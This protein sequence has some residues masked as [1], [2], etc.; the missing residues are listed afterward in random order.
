MHQGKEEKGVS[1][2]MGN[3][4]R[5]LICTIMTVCVHCLP[6]SSQEDSCTQAVTLKDFT[7]TGNRQAFSM[8]NDK[9]DSYLW[10]M[11]MM[12]ELPKILG[13]ADPIHYSQMLPGVQTNNEYRS[14][15]NIQGC[16][17]SHNDINIG[18]IPIY[19][20]NHLLG[21]FSTF[22][23][24]HYPTMY[25]NKSITS[26]QGA[27]RLGGEL[28][29]SIPQDIPDSISGEMAVGVISSQGTLRAPLGQRTAV[30]LSLR[31]S[32]MNMLYGRWL[33]A[34]EMQMKYSFLDSNMTLL[35]RIDSINTL[36]ADFYGG[37][38]D[39]SFYED[40]Y[41]ADMKARWGN[42]MGSLRWLHNRDSTITEQALYITT[43]HNMF[44]IGMPDMAFT[45]PSSITDIGYKVRISSNRITG[46]L[47][48]VLHAITPQNVEN[49]G[50]AYNIVETIDGTTHTLETSVYADYRMPLTRRTQMTAGLR[51]TI[52][53]G[54]DVGALFSIDPSLSV[55]YSVGDINVSAAYSLCH[56]YIFQTGFSDMG[57]P[58][59]FWMSCGNG[60]RPQYA[61]TL[62]AGVSAYL[63]GRR[64]IV[65]ADVFYKKLYN[66]IE[67]NGTVLDFINT[68]YD[69]YNILVNGNGENH[70]FSIM[71]NKCSGI[72][73]GWISYAYTSAKRRFPS[74]GQKRYPSSHE[75]PHEIN[76]VLT[77]SVG[78]HWDFGTTFTYAS[79]T[80]FTAPDHLSLINGNIITQFSEYN[81]ARLKPYLRLD[82]SVNYKWKGR[83]HTRENSL[84]LS[85]YNATGRRNELF[86]YV[87]MHEDGRFAYRPVSFF[88]DIL[89]S[90]SYYCKF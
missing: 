69:I 74:I 36:I 71:V 54:E 55:K 79:G 7:V 30:T 12:N 43:Y 84:N 14:G 31:G 24:A 88:L 49:N 37:F 32:Y 16:E 77:C 22:N 76:S 60:R 86:Y 57:L 42:Y 52:Y 38:D 80:P 70:G 9:R 63:L 81:A 15:V 64:Y 2:Y 48:A 89:P 87:S 8:R 29:M 40:S 20:V 28:S 21:F 78:R 4:C 53:S 73:T 44:D 13:N 50:N 25:L 90:I 27:N 82:V 75:R 66:Q 33:N 18:G 65:S 39:G 85:L 83:R 10:R 46:G 45:L 62:T 34:D 3:M 61:H 26:A 35:H 17:N 72:L 56:Q 58:T 5:K 67:Y 11:Q 23:A 59:E 41:I 1:A 68:E 51:G 19:N 6:A 47:D